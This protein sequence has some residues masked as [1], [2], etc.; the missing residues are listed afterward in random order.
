MELFFAVL[1]DSTAMPQ[2]SVVFILPIAILADV[3]AARVLSVPKLTLP[4]KSAILAGILMT[5]SILAINK[6]LY[7]FMK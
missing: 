4:C 6:T 1:F 2:L 7:N 3:F 5:P